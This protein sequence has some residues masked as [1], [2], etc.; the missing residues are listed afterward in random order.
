MKNKLIIFSIIGILLLSMI[1]VADTGYKVKNLKAV[2]KSKSV[3]VYGRVFDSK[4]KEVNNVDVE[5]YCKHN[6][7]DILLGK[8]NT[9][10]SNSFSIKNS[11]TV[12]VKKD[13]IW[14]TVNGVKVTDTKNI[15]IKKPSSETIVESPPPA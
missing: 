1:V 4:F 5:A 10:S 15:V 7:T 6:N 2:I 12:C 3:T 8:V 13:S 11:N 9:G 14:V